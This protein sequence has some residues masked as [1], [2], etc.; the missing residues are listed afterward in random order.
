MERGSGNPNGDGELIGREQTQHS[1]NGLLHGVPG[2]IRNALGDN[3][4]VEG[5]NFLEHVRNHGET[6]V[7]AGFPSRDELVRHAA[8]VDAGDEASDGGSR[9]GG[10]TTPSEGG[11]E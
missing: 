4:G 9:A 3:G 8:A 1:R 10:Q 2:G 11:G 5:L 6:S 7:E